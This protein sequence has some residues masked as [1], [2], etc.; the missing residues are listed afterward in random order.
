MSTSFCCRSTNYS[1]FGCRVRTAKNGTSK[2]YVVVRWEKGKDRKMRVAVDQVSYISKPAM[3]WFDE[4]FRPREDTD[5]DSVAY[6]IQEET[7][8]EADRDLMEVAVAL[9][10]IEGSRMGIGGSQ[11]W[12]EMPLNGSRKAAACNGHA[13]KTPHRKAR[14]ACIRTACSGTQAVA[15]D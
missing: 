6:D 3:K 11:Y 5:I 2:R 12:V 7:G 1:A 9:S 15:P 10:G 4:M 8:M 14:N 13:T